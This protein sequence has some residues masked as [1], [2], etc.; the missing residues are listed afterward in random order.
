MNGLSCAA[1]AGLTISDEPP[2]RF[3]NSVDDSTA[4]RAVSAQEQVSNL[5]EADVDSEVGSESLKGF[6]TALRQHDVA[7]IGERCPDPTQR[8]R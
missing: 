7:W 2:R 6:E 1:L 3:C 8:L 4:A 5:P